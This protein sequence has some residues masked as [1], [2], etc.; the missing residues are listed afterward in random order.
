LHW[1]VNASRFGLSNENKSALINK[2]LADWTPNSVDEYRTPL[3]IEL[4][5]V[6]KE[7]TKNQYNNGVYIVFFISCKFT[8]YSTN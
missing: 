8:I 5:S 1:K 2:A 3:H 7:A 6:A 4:C